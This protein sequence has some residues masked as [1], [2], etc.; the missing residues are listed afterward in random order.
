M[1]A[2]GQ[3]AL[4]APLAGDPD[5]GLIKLDIEDGSPAASAR[6]MPVE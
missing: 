6:R 2:Q 4:L 1:T 3:Q 5:G